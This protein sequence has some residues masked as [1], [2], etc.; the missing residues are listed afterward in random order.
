MVLIK[1]RQV[2]MLP[3]VD[4]DERDLSWLDLLKGDAVANGDEPVACTVNNINRAGDP[5]DPLVR[6]DVIP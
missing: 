1:F 6:T 3:T 2:V 4:T 5:A